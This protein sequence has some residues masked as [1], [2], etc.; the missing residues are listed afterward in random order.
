[1]DVLCSG[2]LSGV[3]HGFT[4]RVDGDLRPSAPTSA[5]AGATLVRGMAGRFL[6]RVNQVHGARVVTAEEVEA[7]GDDLLDADAIVSTRVDAVLCIRVA[8]CVPILLSTRGGVAA[9]HAGW[10]GTAAGITGAALDRLCRLT[11]ARPSDVRAVVGPCISGE[12]YEVGGEV[13]DALATVAP[14][15][16]GGWRW[17]GARGRDH[18]DIGLLNASILA[19]AGVQVARMPVC[20]VGSPDLWSHRRDGDAAGRQGALIR[21]ANPEG[22]ASG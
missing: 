13:A 18:A 9:V 5:E 7:A 3:P 21:L 8:D 10:K 4:T 16:A 20:T 2:L 22:A 14:A 11:G 19:S 17:V 1:M 15:G 6:A 12:A